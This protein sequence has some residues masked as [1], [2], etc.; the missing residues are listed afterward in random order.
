MTRPDRYFIWTD[1][2]GVLTPPIDAAMAE[3]CI[4]R[5]IRPADLGQALSTIAQRH[6]VADA[7]ELIDTPVM[8][9]ADWLAELNVL[10]GG[11][12]PGESLADAWFDGRPANAAWIEA[13]KDLKR[14]GH[15]VGLL[16]NMVPTW[17]AHWRRMV[18][19][20]GL[21]DAVILSFQVRARKPEAQIFDLAASRAEVPAERCILVD[22][23]VANC[24]GA[25]RAGWKAVHFQDAASA[26]D[27][28]RALIQADQTCLETSH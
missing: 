2:G 26:A 28:L 21:F 16:S 24:A 17:D 25:E 20:D 7:M 9:E 12:L 11:R 4:A 3:F 27:Q 6:G 1:F 18:D 10:L 23:L 19:V 13:L 22:D 5:G 14:A 15:G 8:A